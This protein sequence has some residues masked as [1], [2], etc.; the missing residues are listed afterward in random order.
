MITDL[1]AAGPYL[2]LVLTALIVMG[3]P[4]PA[5]IGATA[6]ATAFGLRRALP[7]LIGSI[8]GTTAVL[9]A[10]AVGLA[11]VLLAEPHVGPV[12]LALSAAYLLYLAYRT[13]TAPPLAVHRAHARAPAWSSGFVLAV[14]NPKAYA[15]LGTVFTGTTLGLPTEQ[16]DALVKTLILTVL[17]VLVHLGWAVAGATFAA[18]LHRPRTA[19]VVNL[20]L[21]AALLGSTIPVVAQHLAMLRS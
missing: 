5:T 6:S 18:A 17:V 21:A 4:G 11:S 15:A 7:Y 19:R 13:A 14:A 10:V 16:L 8:M 9:I 20:V 2:S 3:S 1:P 12:L